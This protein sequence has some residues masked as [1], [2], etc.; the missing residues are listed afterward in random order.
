[1]TEYNQSIYYDRAFY[2]QDIACSIAWA[3]ANHKAGILS[4]EEL[5]G[6]IDGLSKVEKEWKEGT[7]EIKPGIDED[8]HTANERRLSEI[9]GKEVG[10][11]LHTGYAVR[12]SHRREVGAD[13]SN[14]RSRNE[15][16]ATDMR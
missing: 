14:S 3:N 4:Q 2:H 9:I 12:S 7:F 5:E 15:Q 16:V 1:M 8:I 13:E 6:I 11:K 10:G